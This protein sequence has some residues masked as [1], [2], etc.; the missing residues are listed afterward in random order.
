[1]QIDFHT[2]QIGGIVLL[3]WCVADARAA[4]PIDDDIA[5]TPV[6]ALV[7]RPDIVPS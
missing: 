5:P 2:W 1:M 6:L 4:V 3:I 7:A